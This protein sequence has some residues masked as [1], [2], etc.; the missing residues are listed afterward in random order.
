MSSKNPDLRQHT[1]RP[2][3]TD[4]DTPWQEVGP[5]VR[6]KILAH[7]PELMLVRVAFEA[8]AIGPEHTHPHVQCTL[9]ES[10]RFAITIAGTTR[11]LA[12][13]DSFFV[14]SNLPH[15]AVALSAGALLDSFSPMRDEFLD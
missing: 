14:A 7:G 4:A 12:A 6:R 1:G 13:G 15:S 9:V 11:E 8:G 2:F 5:G 3:V 10:G